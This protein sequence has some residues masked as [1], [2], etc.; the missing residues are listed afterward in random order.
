MSRFN[1]EFDPADA[2]FGRPTDQSGRK[3]KR[4]PRG[5][6]RR[7]AYDRVTEK[8]TTPVSRGIY[9][10][11]AMVF[12]DAPCYISQ[13]APLLAK[14]LQ[15]RVEAEPLLTKHLRT[16]E[17]RND[18]LIQD[19]VEYMIRRFWERVPNDQRGNVL[20]TFLSADWWDGL[21]EETVD[22]QKTLRIPDS[23]WKSEGGHTVSAENPF[24]LP[25]ISPDKPAPVGTLAERLK[26]AR[27]KHHTTTEESD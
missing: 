12:R 9:D 18:A 7:S 11:L 4:S 20:S 14:L 16:G 17:R 5:E 8:R 1:D 2:L 23:A 19:M 3:P 10:H 26:A 22:H 25:F 6:A 27:E 21:V 24:Y 13:G 15:D